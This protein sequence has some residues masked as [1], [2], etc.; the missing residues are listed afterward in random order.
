MRS[1]CLL[2]LAMLVAVPCIYF[3]EP[4]YDPAMQKYAVDYDGVS[5]VP[6]ERYLW[7]AGIY[8]VTGVY[9][10]GR[11]FDWEAAAFRSYR[12]VPVLRSEAGLTAFG[13][14]LAGGPVAAIAGPKPGRSVLDVAPT[15]LGALGIGGSFDGRPACATNASQVVVLYVDSLGWDRYGWARPAM[16]N[17]SSLGEPEKALSVYPSISR[18]NAAAMVTGVSP[19]RSGIDRWESRAV[20]SD[21]AISLA[22]GRNVSAA[23]VDGPGPPV[24]LG[25]GMIPVY[26]LD[27]DGSRDEE[28]VDRAIAEYQNGTRL[29]YVHI[30]DMDRALHATGPY[31][32]RSLEAAIWNDALAG[33]LI[34]QLRPGTLLIVVADHGGHEIEGGRGDHGTLLPRDMAIP[35][36]VYRC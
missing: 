21:D 28:V 32:A 31:S 18:V 8:P 30:V 19:E 7:K 34:G 25:Q 3:L 10:G 6:L 33:R 9:A 24:L 23:W 17:L 1:A 4:V 20:L 5:G 16:R 22:L 36:F 35:L 2:V 13:E 26:D 12:H 27:G 14:K 11:Y 29:L 15:A